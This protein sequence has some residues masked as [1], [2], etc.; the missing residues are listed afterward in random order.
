MKEEGPSALEFL[1]FVLYF[2]RVG[3]WVFT[4][5]WTPE[6]VATLKRRIETND[7]SV[8]KPLAKPS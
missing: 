4:C 3:F 2:F 5:L 1:F 8:R 7:F 6:A